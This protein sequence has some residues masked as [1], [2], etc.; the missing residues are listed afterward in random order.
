MPG[1]ATYDETGKEQVQQRTDGP[2]AH[3]SCT[4][5]HGSMA[6]VWYRVDR[7]DDPGLQGKASFLGEGLAAGCSRGPLTV[8][9]VFG[10]VAG[11]APLQ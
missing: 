3:T 4:W 10:S 2:K 5:R 6:T 1:W 9:G 11:P 7:F 8:A